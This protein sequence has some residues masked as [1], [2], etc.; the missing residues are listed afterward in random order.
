MSKLRVDNFAK[1]SRIAI[2]IAKPP[3]ADMFMIAS[4]IFL[5]IIER[6]RMF[7]RIFEV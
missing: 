1:P 3:L 4:R 5:K 6:C 2:A 7:L